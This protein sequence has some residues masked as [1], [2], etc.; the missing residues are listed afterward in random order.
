VAE[1]AQ[2]VVGVHAREGELRQVRDV[3]AEGQHEG[4]AGG[5]A[6]RVERAAVEA[7]AEERFMHAASVEDDVVACGLA[8][9]VVGRFEVEL[10]DEAEA[11]ERAARWWV[12][13]RG[14]VLG[15]GAPG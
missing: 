14:G 9:C 2:P 1:E 12:E 8:G 5:R 15:T 6:E 11:R 7:D 4:Q 13:V 3:D 10:G